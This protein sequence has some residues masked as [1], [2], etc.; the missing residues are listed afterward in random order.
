MNRCYRC[1]DEYHSYSVKSKRY[2][3]MTNG[4]IFGVV[5]SNAEGHKFVKRK[6]KFI[7]LCP[8]CLRNLENYI[9]VF[10]DADK[11]VQNARKRRD[12]SKRIFGR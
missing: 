1:G 2:G 12:K 9:E 10:N 3:V 7:S 5:Y 4:I 8:D 6:E 11:E